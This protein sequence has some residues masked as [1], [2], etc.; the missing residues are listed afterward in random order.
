ME[1]G[2]HGDVAEGAV[3]AE[4][5]AWC[6]GNGNIVLDSLNMY[7]VLDS[8][9]ASLLLVSSIQYHFQDD[10]DKLNYIVSNMTTLGKLNSINFQSYAIMFL[11]LL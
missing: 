7:D 9:I 2:C 5:K 10:D 8:F 6:I 3:R 1:V 11:C 4:Y